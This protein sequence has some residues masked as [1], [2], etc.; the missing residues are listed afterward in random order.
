MTTKSLKVG[1]QR[2]FVF[3]PWFRFIIVTLEITKKSLF[4]GQVDLAE[5][6]ALSPWPYASDNS[7]DV[8]RSQR[9]LLAGKSIFSHCRQLLFFVA[10]A[11]RNVRNL[12]QIR[13]I[14]DERFR[15]CFRPSN[16][17]SNVDRLASFWEHCLDSSYFETGR[18]T[19]SKSTPCKSDC[20]KR[21]IYTLVITYDHQFI[22][23]RCSKIFCVFCLV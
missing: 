3:S 15:P 22:K 17:I 20:L 16:I 18:K 2:Y 13:P 9:P 19:V 10:L 5:C 6:G 14:S 4:S 1:V 12:I 21:T 8:E 11:N 23:S 7:R